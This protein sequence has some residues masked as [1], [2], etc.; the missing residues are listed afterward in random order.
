MRI[1]Q[2]NV[3]MK[4][5]DL[6]ADKFS[7]LVMGLLQ[8]CYPERVALDCW[9]AQGRRSPIHR[10]IWRTA[11]RI[12]GIGSNAAMIQRISVL[13]F[14]AGLSTLAA[15]SELPALSGL[16]FLGQIRQKVGHDSAF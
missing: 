14:G 4:Y 9:R 16:S 11:Q 13:L 15:G 5:W 10:P 7:G 8:R 2:P 1:A 12:S 3:P 6:I